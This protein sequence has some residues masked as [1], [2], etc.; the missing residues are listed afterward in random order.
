LDALE[1][2][3]ASKKGAGIHA[4]AL[5]KVFDALRVEPRY[6]KLVAKTQGN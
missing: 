2:F 1:E 3:A 5:S 6:Q 4:L